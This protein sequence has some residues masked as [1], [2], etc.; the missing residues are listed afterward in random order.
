M[1]NA[2]EMTNAGGNVANTIAADNRLLTWCGLPVYD[3]NVIGETEA[4]LYPKEKIIVGQKDA[5]IYGVFDPFQ[6]T[7]P[8][9]TGKA[10]KFYEITQ[11]SAEDVPIKDKLATVT[12]AHF[13]Q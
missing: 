5:T 9:A 8:V 1:T 6:I 7:G 4:S 12:I 10:Q 13:R 2:D 3:T 11:A